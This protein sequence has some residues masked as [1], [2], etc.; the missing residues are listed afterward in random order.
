MSTVPPAASGK[1]TIA[2]L[3]AALMG[4]VIGGAITY[5][6][7]L[8]MGFVQVVEKPAGA[9]GAADSAA[10]VDAGGPPAG[11]PAMGGPGMGMGGMMPGG[12]GGGGRGGRGGG[13]GGG[14]GGKR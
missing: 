4:I 12:G 13:G 3:G 1:S 10:P 7:M 6:T 8:Q 11:G 9:G 2:T 5:A 14:A